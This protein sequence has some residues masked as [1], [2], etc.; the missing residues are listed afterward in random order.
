MIHNL[1]HLVAHGFP[2][3]ARWSRS[4]QLAF[5]P[6]LHFL[7]GHQR[8]ASLA[9]LREDLPL[10]LL[11]P[12]VVQAT[13]HSLGHQEVDHSKRI[14]VRILK[15]PCELQRVRSQSSM[16]FTSSPQTTAAG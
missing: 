14:D 12:P 10:H 6:S 9:V 13:T 1:L 8:A 5:R 4:G 3:H 2:M 7:M 16:A 15:E 11:V